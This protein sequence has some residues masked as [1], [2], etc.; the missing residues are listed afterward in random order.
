LVSIFGCEERVEF[1]EKVVDPIHNSS[2]KLCMLN[3]PGMQAMAQE[4]L[5]ELESSIHRTKQFLA[6]AQERQQQLQSCNTQLSQRCSNAVAAVGAIQSI[7]SL[8]PVVSVPVCHG[9]HASRPCF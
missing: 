1:S 3:C 7:S 6:N 5:I 2:W 9:T 4:K 8:L